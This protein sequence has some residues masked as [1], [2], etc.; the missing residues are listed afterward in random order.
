MTRAMFEGALKHSLASLGHG[1]GGGGGGLES[2]SARVQQHVFNTLGILT[3]GLGLTSVPWHGPPPVS[4]VRRTVLQPCYLAAL[5][6]SY[7]S[8]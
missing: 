7:D 1:G 4:A 2:H 6:V 3:R 5:I 8:R